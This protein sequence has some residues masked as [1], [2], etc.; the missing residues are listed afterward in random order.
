[1]LVKVLIHILH[2]LLILLL[3]AVHVHSVELAELDPGLLMFEQL[4]ARGTVW[5]DNELVGTSERLERFGSEL[6]LAPGAYLV[7]IKS[8]QGH[9]CRSSLEVRPESVIALRC[10]SA[11]GRLHL[12]MRRRPQLPNDPTRPAV[13]FFKVT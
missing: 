11:T 4:P 1:M 10:S 2:G 8:P 6:L 7:S 9:A 13:A 12:R 3:G 5:L